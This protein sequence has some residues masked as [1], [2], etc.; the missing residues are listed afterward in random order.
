[1][2]TSPGRQPVIPPFSCDS[3]LRKCSRRRSLYSWCIHNIH[4][5]YKVTHNMQGIPDSSVF[6]HYF[7]V[8]MRLAQYLWNAPDR[9]ASI[10]L[11]KET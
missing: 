1:M 2:R 3:L 11:H 5:V 7:S 9:S 8:G 10:N 4:H 6:F